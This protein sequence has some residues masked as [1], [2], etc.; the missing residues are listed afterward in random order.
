MNLAYV[1]T[2]TKDNNGVKYLL[3]CRDL[4]DRTVDA[5]GLKTKF[6]KKT[7]DDFTSINTKKNWPKK[8]W[9]DKGT[10]IAGE[11]KAAFAEHTTWSLKYILYRYME[12]K[13][14]SAFL[15]WLNQ[16]QEIDLW[17]WF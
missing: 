6:S 14:T 4:F 7:V 9:V 17:T 15:N 11:T 12:K 2:L 5:K 16:L 1:N 13:N 8:I 10:K 3:V